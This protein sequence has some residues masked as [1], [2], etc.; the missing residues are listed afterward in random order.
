MKP[1]NARDL[2]QKHGVPKELAYA[3]MRDIEAEERKREPQKRGKD[4]D[5]VLAPLRTQIKSLGSSQSLWGSDIVR[6]PVYAAY[7]ALLRK[8]RDKIE[9]VRKLNTEDKTIPEIAAER[10]LPMR[11]LRW[12]AWVPEN[13]KTAFTLEFEKMYDRIEKPG[14]RLLP[15]STYVERTASDVRWDNLLAYCVSEY[16][17]RKGLGEEYSPLL[18]ALQEATQAI[19]NRPITQEAPVNWEH[20]L[21]AYTKQRLEVWRELSLNGLR[22]VPRELFDDA[23][24]EAVAKNAVEKELRLTNRRAKARVYARQWRANRKAKGDSHG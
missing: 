16:E 19:Y 8:V 20:L 12:A 23:A 1:K 17:G 6:A 3:L 24:K 22:E 21:T 2:F 18:E 4:W 15:F 11:G 9:T 7:L 5:Y 14:R 13:V 10:G